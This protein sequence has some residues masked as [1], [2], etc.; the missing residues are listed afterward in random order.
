MKQNISFYIQYIDKNI[1]DFTSRKHKGQGLSTGNW[2]FYSNTDIKWLSQYF[3]QF[4]MPKKDNMPVELS[5]RNYQTIKDD[6]P[7]SISLKRIC[8]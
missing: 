5:A 4:D 3:K 6:A 7:V 2:G 1:T 8:R